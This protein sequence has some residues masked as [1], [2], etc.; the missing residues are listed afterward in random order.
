MNDNHSTHEHAAASDVNQAS[1]AAKFFL[2][3]PTF[4][5]LLGILMTLGGIMSY[6]V[7]TKESLPD[8]EIPQATVMTFWSGT[9]PQTIEQEITNKLEKESRRSTRCGR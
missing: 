9:D 7:L 3:R 8:L 5:V 2:L 1:W 6:F 4:G